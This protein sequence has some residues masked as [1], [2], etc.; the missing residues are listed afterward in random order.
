MILFVNDLTVID[1]SYLHPSRGAIGESWIVDLTLHGDLN[2]E[3]M[4]LDFSLVKKQVK[5]I[6]DDVIDH[7]LAVPTLTSDL[8]VKLGDKQSQLNFDFDNH[9]L[10]MSSPNQAFCFIE[11]KEI[12]EQ[13]VTQYLI[14]TI[15]PQL[16]DNIAKID[17]ELRPEAIQSFYYHYSHG[18]KKHDGN[19]QRIVHGHRSTIGIEENGMRSV[20]LQKEW[21]TKWQD[22]YLV[23]E[24]DIIAPEQLKH[25]APVEGEC[26]LRIPRHKGT[27]N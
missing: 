20:K 17:I 2:N 1:F 16:P 21:A 12:N 24:E 14:D 23:S 27:L 13:T 19:C 5:R 6:I 10:A 3:S 11:T 8:N 26:I 9:S 22:I 4:I 15:L 18:L 7:K 25:I